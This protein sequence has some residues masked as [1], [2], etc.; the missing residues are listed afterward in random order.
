[1]A[2]EVFHC[3][4]AAVRWG[5]AVGAGVGALLGWALYAA[6]GKPV[7]QGLACG[8]VEPC[9]IAAGLAWSC[10]PVVSTVLAAAHVLLA[11]GA[12]QMPGRTVLLSKAAFAGSLAYVMVLTL[13]VWYLDCP[14]DAHCLIA[15]FNLL[16]TTAGAVAPNAYYAAVAAKVLPAELHNFWTPD[17]ILS[18]EL[19]RQGWRRPTPRAQIPCLWPC[20]QRQPTQLVQTRCCRRAGASG[21]WCARP[22]QVRHGWG[23]SLWSAVLVQDRR[24]VPRLHAC[25]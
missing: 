24:G 17:G 5:S 1:M 21:P 10:A 12:C 19:E 8:V 20:A 13:A 11:V 25:P 18:G 6:A 9:T 3:S 23:G 16:G 4:A 15:V 7:L 22:G 2:L 14:P